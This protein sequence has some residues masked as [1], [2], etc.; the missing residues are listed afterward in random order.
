MKS[1][2]PSMVLMAKVEFEASLIKISIVPCFACLVYLVYWSM[3]GAQ[4][5]I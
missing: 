5:Q 1:A 3:N 2:I 4:R